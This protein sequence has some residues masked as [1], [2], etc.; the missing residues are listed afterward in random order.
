MAARFGEPYLEPR[1]FEYILERPFLKQVLTWSGDA[2]L[3]AFAFLVT[4]GWGAHYWFSF[5]RNGETDG[6]PPG[7]GYLVDFLDWA[8]EEQLPFAYL[9]TSYGQKSRYKSRGMD[10]IEFWDGNG[11]SGDRAALARLRELDNADKAPET[12]VRNPQGA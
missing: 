4:G 7:H 6:S 1:R 12:A 8:R 9:G 10:G 2:G 11:W 3:E 5:Y